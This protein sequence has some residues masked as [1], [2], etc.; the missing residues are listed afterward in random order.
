LEIQEITSK[1][2]VY[3]KSFELQKE[4]INELTKKIRQTKIIDIEEMSKNINKEREEKKT[5][6]INTVQGVVEEEIN[7][8]ELLISSLK[9][10]YIKLNKD[11]K[12]LEELKINHT[13]IENSIIQIGSKI[14]N[15]KEKIKELEL[16]EYDK[17][18]INKL[19]TDTTSLKEELQK[20]E[21]LTETVNKRIK[22]LKFW[23]EGFSNT[24]IKSMLIDSAI[25]LMN[26]VV[27][28][29]LEKL[30]HGKF[31][32]SFDTLSE[33]K[34]GDI[35]DKFKVR[36]LNCENGAD[37]HLLLSGGEKRLVDLCCMKALRA[38][39]ENM[40]QK[41]FR[42]TIFDEALDSLDDDNSNIFC[43]LMKRMSADQSILII[44]HK[45]L[46]QMEVDEVLKL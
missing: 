15:E 9:E 26:R 10:N 27:S 17:S 24:G 35:R 37:K 25:P 11:L 19:K 44:T 30:T 33:T 14:N 39:S 3:L 4:N 5:E 7:K 29:E 13:L 8:I 2:L 34:S 22:I 21:N 16:F 45:T 23:K 20:L 12:E 38:L 28:E 36:I 18:Q 6:Q 40:Y 42:I 32:V 41:K 46:Q 43:K 31:I 1:K